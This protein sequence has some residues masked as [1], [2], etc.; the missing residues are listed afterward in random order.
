MPG[1][2]ERQGQMK[3]TLK[4]PTVAEMDALQFRAHTAGL[5]QYLVH[6]AGHTQI[7]PGS[8]T[9]LAIGPAPASLLDPLTGHLRLYA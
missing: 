8:K 1:S 5:P 7:D 6:D 2:W 4:C 3:I 9:V